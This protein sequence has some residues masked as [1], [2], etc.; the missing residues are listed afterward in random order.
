MEEK[1][2]SPVL[3]AALTYGGIFSVALVLLSVVLEVTGL[4]YKVWANYLSIPLIIGL[5]IYTLTAYKKEYLGG[6]AKFEQLMLMT[7]LMALVAALIS[8]LYS[9][10]YMTW[11]DPDMLDK[12]KNMQYEMLMNNPRIPE[13][14]I[15][16]SMDMF[17]KMKSKPL[18]LVFGFVGTYL[19]ILFWGLIIAAIV[20]KKNPAEIVA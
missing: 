2:K 15:D 5:L 1:A 4:S 6:F 7:L 10:I 14:A 18:M 11:I 16:D 9:F 19:R 8:T 20:K 12:I 3:K 17:E 13:E